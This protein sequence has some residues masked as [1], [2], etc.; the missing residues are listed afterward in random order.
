MVIY[1]LIIYIFIFISVF[2]FSTIPMYSNVTTVWSSQNPGKAE[3][4]WA[5]LMGRLCTLALGSENTS[6]LSVG[7]HELNK[8]VFHLFWGVEF[9]VVNSK[10]LGQ[11]ASLWLALFLDVWFRRIILINQPPVLLWQI[12]WQEHQWKRKKSCSIPLS[13]HRNVPLPITY[14]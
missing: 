1:R 8:V 11:F 5:E 12:L 6:S 7:L 10:D 9:A 4:R 2:I 14:P 13:L 3:P